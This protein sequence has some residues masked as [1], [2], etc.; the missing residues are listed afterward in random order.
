MSI[1]A[2]DFSGASATAESGMRW[3]WKAWSADA[4][5]ASARDVTSAATA[6]NAGHPTEQWRGDLLTV[7]YRSGSQ[8]PGWP[9]RVSNIQPIDVNSQGSFRAL[10]PQDEQPSAAG[11]SST[12]RMARRRWR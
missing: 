5:T 9:V 10:L 8:E 12:L 1:T 6:T 3:V 2:P 7:S 4:G 11:G